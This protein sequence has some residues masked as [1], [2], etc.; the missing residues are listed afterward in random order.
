MTQPAVS[1]I[2][3]TYQMPAHLRR[4]LAA[5]ELQTVASEMEVIVSDDGSTDE[6]AAVV[7]RFAAR[8][9][10]PVK[11]IS[12]PHEGFQLSRTR[13]QG[14]LNASAPH[15]VFLD[16][17]C[18]IEPDYLEQHLK[19]RRPGHVT[20]TYCVRLDEPTSLQITVESI[21]S[22]EYLRWVPNS[23]RRKL[24]VM[25]LKAWWYRA[26][27]HSR[28]PTL[29]G[30]N[31]GI[32]R[33]DYLRINGYDER[34]KAWGKEDDDLG[35][36]LRTLNIKVDYILHRTR[37]YH[38]WH[39]P[40]SSKPQKY[41]D[42]PNYAYLTRKIR[43][44]K[45]LAGLTQRSPAEVTI[46]LNGRAADSLDVLRWV[47]G[48]GCQI[49]R[50]VNAHC[51][52]E[53]ALASD[54][55]YSKRCDCRVLFADGDTGQLA[56]SSKRADIVLSADGLLGNDQQVRVPFYDLPGFFDAIGFANP[57]AELAKGQPQSPRRSAA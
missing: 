3:T 33:E 30:G 28:R 29:R 16:G 47:A 24:W 53:L 17:D 2:V 26:I 8:A 42:G 10:F 43:L 50:D 4:V 7:E 31:M 41:K 18:L 32:A 37:T 13:N 44:T 54:V 5:V 49:V 40:A 51:D 48:A 25:Q 12:L 55:R 34:F 9:P 22:G 19:S 56:S 38:L 15:V 57:L 39:P 11:F 6:T 23:E 52:F 36:R 27:G 45:S 35:Q 46:R 1:L 21:R 14:V 20:N